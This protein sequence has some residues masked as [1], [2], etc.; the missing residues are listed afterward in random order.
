M[1]KILA[2]TGIRSEYDI[3][4]PVIKALKGDAQFDVGV[5][6][7]GAHLSGLHGNT[8]SRIEAD[9]F[10]IVDKIDSLLM[11][12]SST[13]RPKG[14]GILTYGLAQAVDREKPDFLLVVGD[15]EESIATA[16]IGN[17][18]DILTAHIGGGDSV[19]GNADDPTR[20]AVSK[21]SHIHFVMAKEH[22]QNLIDCG[23]EDFRIFYIGNPGLDN[24]R[25]TR[26]IN[27]R[28][29]SDFLGFDIVSSEYIVL[30]KHPLSS[31]K[32]QAYD[33]MKAALTAIQ[34]FC[35]ESKCK[36]IGIYPNTDPGSYDI[37]RAF[38]EF[39]HNPSI[40][41]FNSLPRE[42][43][44]NVMRNAHALAGNSSMGILEAPFYRLPVVNI[45]NRQKGRLNAGNVEF[46]DYGVDSIKMALRKACLDESYRNKISKLQSPYGDGY[47]AQRFKESILKIDPADKKWH[48]KKRMY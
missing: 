28:E 1:K 38:E 41:F 14:V 26:T 12:N 4:S 30:I 37:M 31:E 39:K 35:E 2:V 20:F 29:L 47:A 17:Y 11:T 3:L 16:I 48:I 18:M 9:G 19:Y 24:I 22:A 40:K 23:E 8:I 43:F 21:L 25:L 45:G 33:Q 34:S 10:R 46:V 15:R 6:G 13:Q 44:V 5:V 27:R 7:S 36:I 32:E 42:I